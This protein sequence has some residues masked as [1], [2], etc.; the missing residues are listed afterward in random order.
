MHLPFIIV[1]GVHPED[2]LTDEF[3]ETILGA[4]GVVER[5]RL[6]VVS[7]DDFKV[8]DVKRECKLKEHSEEMKSIFTVPIVCSFYEFESESELETISEQ[9]RIIFMSEV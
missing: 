1:T 6:E 5:F 3:R 4:T 8:I 7:E 9:K 2:D